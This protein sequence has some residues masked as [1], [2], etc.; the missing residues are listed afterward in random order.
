MLTQ[1]IPYPQTLVTDIR[2]IFGPYTVDGTDFV[3]GVATSRARD[4]LA[5]RL[6]RMAARVRQDAASPDGARHRPR[7]VEPSA[8]YTR[9]P[10]CTDFIERD[11]PAIQIGPYVLHANPCAME[12]AAVRWQGMDRP[13][14]YPK[15]RGGRRRQRPT[16]QPS[17]GPSLTLPHADPASSVARGHRH[18]AATPSP[19]NPRAL[20]EGDPQP[21]AA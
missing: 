14:L 3:T 11:V 8:R 4:A 9:C 7:R 1:P 20:P 13:P 19:D 5:Y 2:D 15:P 12:Y 10:W 17:N 16:P 21:P 6:V 18:R